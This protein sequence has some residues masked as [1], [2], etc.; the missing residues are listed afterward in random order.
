[1]N[2]L[3]LFLPSLAHGGAERVMLNIAF[4]LQS[5]ADVDVELLLVEASGP[6][7]EQA[8]ENGIR[9]V[10]LGC[11][12]II[13]SV[14]KV[15]RYLRR[16][17]PMAVLSALDTTNLVALWAARLARVDTRVVV[18]EHCNF[19]SALAG[20][21]NAQA[22]LLPPL[23]SR[24]Y[25]WADAIVAVSAGVADDLAQSTGVA[26]ESMTVVFNPVITPAVVEAARLEPEH[27]WFA[28]H[29][30]PIVLGIGRLTYQKNFEL[31]VEAFAR[32]SKRA[33]ARLIILGEGPDREALQRRIDSLGLSER[34]DMPGFVQNPY[35]YMKAA[36]LFVLS[37]RYEGLPT[38]L[39]EALYCGAPV[40]ATDCPSGPREILRGGELGELVPMDDAEALEE[41]M[42]AV[43]SESGKAATA[44][45]ALD[46]YRLARVTER[47]AAIMLGHPSP[48]AS[49]PGLT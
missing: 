31:L 33:P 35:A 20:A 49:V 14:P 19:S 47:Y 26:R 41:A 8:R 2:K 29:G 22:R 23:V 4:G 28:D 5:R 40:I 18:S 37:S 11:S 36:S 9:V 3:T 1:M 30:I 10:D 16:R 25:P 24:F 46:D 45:G 48:S 43:L 39:I 17:R 34:V 27:R 13:S 15:V 42:S 21:R 12:R 6:Y 38:V 32:L 44:A 7:L